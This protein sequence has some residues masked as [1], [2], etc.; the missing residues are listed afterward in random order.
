[1]IIHV[2]KNG[3]TLWGTA[4]RYG[5]DV[6]KIIEANELPDPNKLVIGQALVIPGV[7]RKHTV[8]PREMLWQIAQFYGTTVQELLEVNQIQN[9]N[10]ITPGMV[11]T[12]PVRKPVIDVNAYVINM[13]EEGAQ[14]VREVGE[15]LTYAAPF[16]YIMQEDGGLTEINDTEVIRAAVESRAIAMMCITNFTAADPGSKLAQTILG[17]KEIQERLLN[18]IVKTMKEKGYQ[19]LNIDFENVYPE[20]RE[21]YNQFLRRAVDRLHKE[22]YFVSTALAPKTSGDQKGLLYEAH[23]YRAHG[24]IVDFVILMTYEWGYRF[25]PPQ[26]I[27]PLNQI[28]Q[29][30]D[31]AVTV[32]PREKIFFGFQLYA[33]DWLLPHV[34]GQEAETF[35]MQE[36]VRRAVKHGAVIQ[37]DQTSQAPFFR[38]VDEEGRT[39]EVWFEDARSAQAKFDMVKDYRLRGISYWVLGYPFPQN[40]LLLGENFTIRKRR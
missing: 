7:V 13:G 35:D 20:D 16:A 33:R 38:Y 32:I 21:Q 29:V 31:Y 4:N 26:A 24:R 36:A 8:R 14:D 27:S 34:E 28:K 6:S 39:H 19:G 25:G 12:I 37:Y 11:L 9:P 18:N 40:W 5:V 22:N 3:D 15:Y 2:V 30:L 10:L 23:D 17:S 1:M